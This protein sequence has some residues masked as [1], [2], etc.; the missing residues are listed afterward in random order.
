MLYFKSIPFPENLTQIDLENALRK[1]SLKRTSSLD[2]KSCTSDMGKDRLF[3]GLDRKKDLQ[4]TRLKTSFEVLLPKM[5][6]KLSKDSLVKEYKVRLSAIPLSVAFVLC[7]GI[8]ANI[9]ALFTG[10]GSLDSIILIAA[11]SLIFIGLVALELKLV[12]GNIDKAVISYEKQ[13]STAE[14]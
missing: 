10:K 9:V 1:Q 12:K 13:L 8:F 7:F 11:L 4:F 14:Y 5:I 2:F 3:L 6:I